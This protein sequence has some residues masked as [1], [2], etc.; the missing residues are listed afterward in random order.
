MTNRTALPTCT[1][2][3]VG[4]SSRALLEMVKALEK[5][6]T[7]MHGIMLSRHG[8]LIL[9]GWWRPYTPETIHICH[10][11]GKSYVATAIGKACTQGLLSVE[12][13]IADLFAPEIRA[14]GLDTSGNLGK[15][16]V[17]HL[18]TMTNGMSVHA[19]AGEHLVRNY[20]TTPVDLEPGSVFMY[21]TAGSCMLAE[22]VRR[23][24]DR[25]VLDYLQE[26]VLEPIGCDMEHFRW[27]TFP[28]GLHA[29]PGVA[30]CTENNLRLGMLYLNR[31]A[32][33]GTQLI[34]PEWIDQ[35]TRRQV[36]NGASGYGYQ[37]WLN[38]VPGTYRFSGGHGQDCLMSPDRDMVVA[39]HQAGS[40]PHDTDAV[41]A[42]V[43]RALLEKPLPETLPPDPEGAQALAE[44]MRTRKIASAG[45]YAIHSF[46]NGWEGRYNTVEG[47]FH[48]Q[49]ELRPAGEMNV[50]ADFYTDSNPDVRTM[51]IE[52]TEEGFCLT[53]NDSLRIQARLD[54]EWRPHMAQSAMPAYDQSCAV[55]RAD[56]NELIVEQ[57][58]YQTC[59][60]TRLRMTRDGELLH[61]EARKERLHDDRPYFTLRAVMKRT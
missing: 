3:S 43:N 4:V 32:W 25:S 57:W 51:V 58:F 34:D 19:L 40:E 53:L 47:C 27:M 39:I 59:F 31:G 12:D 1:P 42:I 16:R 6:G 29:A 44:H 52:R 30:S 23:V 5:S 33:Q 60:K 2:E 8:R 54:G 48:L 56:E 13:R 50:N 14:W 55:A 18:L 45:S 61:I 38:S 11:F 41:T 28:G 7:E 49:P 46:A 22:I 9:E 15:L 17:K 35:A 21:N 36:D 37:L 10:S 26:T 24:T 20:L